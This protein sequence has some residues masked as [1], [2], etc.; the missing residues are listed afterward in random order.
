MCWTV[1]KCLLNGKA[2]KTSNYTFQP[3][4]LGNINKL[5]SRHT[6]FTRD[7]AHVLQSQS[8]CISLPLTMIKNTEK[9]LFLSLEFCRNKEPRQFCSAD[10]NSPFVQQESGYFHVMQEMWSTGHMD[11]DQSEVKTPTTSEVHLLWDNPERSKHKQLLGYFVQSMKKNPEETN[12]WN[13]ANSHT[14]EVIKYE[15]WI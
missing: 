1:L 3:V 11:Q 9:Y 15:L 2:C 7:L 13:N 6:V 10:G 8:V 14:N 5:S 12:I 4:H